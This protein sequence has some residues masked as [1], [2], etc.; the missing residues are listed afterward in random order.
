[1]TRHFKRVETQR[2]RESFGKPIAGHQAIQLE[3]GEMAARTRAAQLLTEG[4]ARAYDAGERC[5]M[6][7]MRIHGGY[8]HSREYPVERL[9]PGAPLMCIGEGPQRN[10]AHRD[11]AP[12]HRT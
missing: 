12:A 6:E 2:Y 8:G 11:R 3:L 7:A 5:D 9:Y 1:M 4:A 10:A